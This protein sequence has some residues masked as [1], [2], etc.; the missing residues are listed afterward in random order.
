[1]YRDFSDRSKNELLGLVSEVENEKISNFTDWVGDR[2]YD[3]ESWIGKLNIKNY[4]NN[5]NDYHKKVIDKNN[6]TQSSINTIFRKVKSVDT[7][8]KNTLSGKKSQLQQWQRY[9]DEMSQIVNPRNGK[10]NAKAMSDALDG[11]LKQLSMDEIN[12]SLEEYVELDKTTQKYTYHWNEI[13]DLLSR[14]KDELTETEYMTLVAILNTMMNEQGYIDTESLQHFINLGY[15][16]P[17][18]VTRD[19]VHTSFDHSEL[20]GHHSYVNYNYLQ[21][22]AYLNE[23]FLTTVVLYDTIFQNSVSDN[24]SS[25]LNDLLKIIV[26]DYSVIEWRMRLNLDHFDTEQ[27]FWSGKTYVKEETLNYFNNNCVPQIN[28]QYCNDTSKDGLMYYLIYSNAY[29]NGVETADGEPPYTITK[30]GVKHQDPTIKLYVNCS[31]DESA[32]S[33]MVNLQSESELSSFYQDYDLASGVAKNIIEFAISFIPGGE[34]INGAISLANSSEA[35]EQISGSMNLIKKSDLEDLTDGTKVEISSKG[36]KAIDGGIDLVDKA[37]GIYVD[38][39]KSELNNEKVDICKKAVDNLH[40][41]LSNLKNLG[42]RYDTVVVRYDEYDKNNNYDRDWT[43]YIENKKNSNSISEMDFMNYS[44]DSDLLLS[45][46]NN[47]KKNVGEASVDASSE[48]FLELQKQVKEYIATGDLEEG[49]YLS[50]YI[51]KW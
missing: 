21:N 45:E 46:Y 11:L 6:A 9:I 32:D 29:D 20:A 28:I 25:N 26:N 19:D 1:M 23:T 10:F 35:I 49:S 5:V 40:N 30:D 15:T 12:S 16:T 42:I 14:P 37:A 13:E 2:W 47:T 38:Y 39:K 7:S 27:D 43:S 34:Y 17:S 44:L 50:N 48:E 36:E 41:E 18:A 4:L 24:S 51:S 3:F 33:R 22:K 8:Y 31:G